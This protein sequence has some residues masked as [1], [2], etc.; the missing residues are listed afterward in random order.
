MGSRYLTKNELCLYK[1]IGRNAKR[2]SNMEAEPSMAVVMI[3]RSGSQSLSKAKMASLNVNR[4][5]PK[6]QQR[7]VSL[8]L[9]LLPSAIDIVNHHIRA[10]APC[11]TPSY[12]HSPCTAITVLARGFL[13]RSAFKVDPEAGEIQSEDGSND[14]ND[15]TPAFS[16]SKHTLRVRVQLFPARLLIPA[17]LMLPPEATLLPGLFIPIG[18]IQRL[19]PPIPPPLVPITGIGSKP[20]FMLVLSPIMAPYRVVPQPAPCKPWQLLKS[21]AEG[22]TPEEVLDAVERIVKD[23]DLANAYLA[24]SNPVLGAAFIRREITRFPRSG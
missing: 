20:P 16:L 13:P 12:S 15:A 6:H 21:K 5:A 4:L 1:S 14:V 7:R 18:P 22:F 10:D 23:P 9:P 11:S 2:G 3:G 19:I 8:D 17:P 24:L